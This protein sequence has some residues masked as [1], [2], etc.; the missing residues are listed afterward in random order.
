L[1]EAFASSSLPTRNI[2]LIFTGPENNSLFTHARN[3]GVAPFIRFLGWLPQEELARVY[4]GALTIAFVSLYEG[5][6]LP[7]LEGM[8]AKVPVLT[9][10]SSALPEVAGGA[11]L[12]IDPFSIEEI[13]KGLERLTTDEGLRS[14]LIGRGAERVKQ[15]DWH[16]SIAEVW[17]IVDRV[18]MNG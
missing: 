1:I 14:E 7:I 13:A 2:H 3:L 15:F 6:G 18:A 5:F 11:A 9:S 16:R 12:I 17:S 8:A 10:N 4:R